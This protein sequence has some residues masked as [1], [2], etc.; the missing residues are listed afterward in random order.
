VEVAACTWAAA[1]YV[2]GVGM[3]AGA[4]LAVPERWDWSANGRALERAGDLAFG[5]G[6]FGA[7]VLAPPWRGT[8]G[9]GTEGARAA[10]ANMA[11]GRSSPGKVVTVLFGM[12]KETVAA[13]SEP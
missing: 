12:G 3:N 6:D 9:A 7:P 8:V 1:V 11:A 5:P 13:W 4:A 10:R 2:A